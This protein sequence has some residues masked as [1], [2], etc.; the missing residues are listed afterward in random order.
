LGTIAAASTGGTVYQTIYQRTIGSTLQV[1][2]L[3]YFTAS[4]GDEY[5][6]YTNI[7]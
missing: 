3:W 4:T 5:G 2:D 1:K 6:P 7:Y